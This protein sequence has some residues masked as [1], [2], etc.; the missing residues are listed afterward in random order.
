[1]RAYKTPGHLRDMAK[2]TKDFLNRDK[3]E[4]KD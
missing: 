1:M 3:A 4:A 2:L